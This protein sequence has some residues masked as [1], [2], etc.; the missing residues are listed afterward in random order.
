MMERK[1]WT[2]RQNRRLPL[3][4]RD[5]LPQPQSP[6]PPDGVAQAAESPT[7]EASETSSTPP[8]ARMRSRVRRLFITA[9]NKFGL[10][11]RYSTK[12]SYDPEEQTSMKDLSNIPTLESPAST[13]QSFYPYPNLNAFRLHE[14][15]WQGGVQK[16]QASFHDLVKIIGDPEFHSADV[17]DV[18]WDKIDQQLATD[19]E[20]QWLDDDAGWT[21]TPVTISVP[22]QKRRGQPSSPDAG[23]R[24]YV[25][26]DFYHRSLVAVIR[27]KLLGLGDSHGFHFEP[28]ELLWQPVIGGERVRVHGE[29]Y[30]SPAFINAHQEV[31]DLPGEPGCDLPRVVVA[32]MF[33]SDVTHLTSFGNA[34][35]WPLYMFFGNES[36][37]ARCK[38]SCHLCEHIA[39]FQTV[40]RHALFQRGFSFTTLLVASRV[41][42]RFCI[43]ADGRRE[44]P[45][46]V[47]HDLLS[48]RTPTCTVENS[49]RRRLH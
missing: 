44:S 49:P 15:Y 14:W 26:G 16:S 1:P 28:Y 33:W 2:R 46:S 8:A 10:L 7:A 4:F 48:P 19:D 23:P 21:R 43:H 9:R 12:P 35:L 41:L 40:G 17:R 31:Q 3:R 13:N 27:E 45:K 42:Q 22:Y 32:L 38:P 29:L 39:Y 20:E 6:L 18:K 30:T 47:V 5:I 37:Y 34:K 11:R 25:V 36:K 24:N